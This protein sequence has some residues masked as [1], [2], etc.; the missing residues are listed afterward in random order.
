MLFFF[1]GWHVLGGV[2]YLSFGAKS[3]EAGQHVWCHLLQ[4]RTHNR[5]H[6]HAEEFTLHLWPWGTGKCLVGLALQQMSSPC[7]LWPLPARLICIF[8]Y[9]NLIIWILTLWQYNVQRIW[10]AFIKHILHNKFI[11]RTNFKHGLCKQALQVSSREEY[12]IFWTFTGCFALL[13]A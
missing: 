9:F 4:Q 5:L 8:C 2:K 13:I 12:I 10:K 7:V 3:S 11:C 6:C 1:Q